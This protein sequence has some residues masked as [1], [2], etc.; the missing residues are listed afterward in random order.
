[1]EHILTFLVLALRMK[2]PHSI[3]LSSRGLKPT[4]FAQILANSPSPNPHPSSAEQNTTSPFSGLNVHS[5]T[6]YQDWKPQK[7]KVGG[8]G[9]GEM[10][11]SA[12]N[13]SVHDASCATTFYLHLPLEQLRVQQHRRWLSSSFVWPTS[14]LPP[15]FYSL[16]MPHFWSDDEH[17][18]QYFA[19]LSRC[20]Y[21]ASCVQSDDAT[22]LTRETHV[23]TLL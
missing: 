13:G 16:V 14:T 12:M 2:L 21:H 18:Q 20:K 23:M 7:E 10:V 15:S 4:R 5:P 17:V 1:M 8:W 19:W 3:R 9:D 6:V 22:Y 11:F